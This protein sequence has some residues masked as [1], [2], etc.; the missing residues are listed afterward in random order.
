M[1]KERRQSLRGG[2]AESALG[3]GRSLIG[4]GLRAAG[5]SRKPVGGIGGTLRERERGSESMAIRESELERMSMASRNTNR[6]RHMS[7][8]FRS[9]RSPEREESLV[10]HVHRRELGSRTL[11]PRASTSMADYGY[12][13]QPHMS[14]VDSEDSEEEVGS[15]SGGR[16]ASHKSSY[17]VV[18]SS[19]D[20]SLTRRE[21]SL[22]ER[23]RELGKRERE[24]ERERPGSVIGRHYTGGSTSTASSSTPRDR[25]GQFA[26]LRRTP[27]SVSPSFS[28]SLYSNLNLSIGLTNAIG[29]CKTH[30]RQFEH[31]RISVIQNDTCTRIIY[32]NDP[33]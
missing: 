18:M 33:C 26:T 27:G 6:S 13:S 5:L 31:V 19:R 25:T 7:V 20:A 32:R 17:G 11:P 10:K 14:A 4:E 1:Q 9:S 8:D 16:K 21:Q 22:L 3:V 28:K 12:T 23:E 29:T 24:L 2:S 15:R 30:G